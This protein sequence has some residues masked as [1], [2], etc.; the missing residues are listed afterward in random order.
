M[1]DDQREDIPTLVIG[2]VV[3]FGEL[4]EFVPA[5][6][7]SAVDNG[8]YLLPISVSEIRDG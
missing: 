7:L 5:F 6:L 2:G 4:I 1:N 8:I 3:L